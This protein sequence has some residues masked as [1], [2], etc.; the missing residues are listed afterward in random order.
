MP[1]VWTEVEVEVDLSDFS[2]RDLE[3]ELAARGLMSSTGSYPGQIQ[4]LLEEIW[5]LR[6]TAQPYDAPLDQLLWATVG[7]VI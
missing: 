4:A 2:D 6:R 3:E 7:R 5:L 1:T